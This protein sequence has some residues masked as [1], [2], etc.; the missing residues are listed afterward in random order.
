LLSTVIAGA[1]GLGIAALSYYGTPPA[2]HLARVI[3]G[4]ACFYGTLALVSLLSAAIGLACGDRLRR[5]QIGLGPRVYSRPGAGLF[6]D[7]RAVPL[8]ISFRMRQPPGAPGSGPRRFAVTVVTAPVVALPLWLPA[9]PASDRPVALVGWCGAWLWTMTSVEPAS[10]RTWLG[11]ALGGAGGGPVDDRLLRFHVAV[12]AVAA[13][14]VESAR[15]ELECGRA[16]GWPDELVAILDLALGYTREDYPVMIKKAE[17]LLARD[18]S[19]A[20]IPMVPTVNAMLAQA[21]HRAAEADQLPLLDAVIRADMAVAASGL[22]RDP[23]FGPSTT[24]LRSA[25]VGDYER[26]LPAARRAVEAAE[27]PRA[28]A[29]DLCTLALVYS[30]LGQRRKAERALERAAGLAPDLVRIAATRRR[31]E[32]APGR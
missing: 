5:V 30:G 22:S 14:D 26:A 10:G 25:L 4:F 11:F 18:W 20:V 21:L 1:M 23:T 28:R 8:G 12:E 24:A 31:I 3:V 13:G 32:G 6:L 16:E 9:V 29:D 15:A 2:L 17:D 19:G 27:E 7:V